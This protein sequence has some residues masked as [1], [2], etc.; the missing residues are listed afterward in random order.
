MEA[1]LQSTGPVAFQIHLPSE[2]HPYFASLLLFAAL[3]KVFLFAF[4]PFPFKD[5]NSRAPKFV[6][7]DLRLL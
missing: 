5:L 4:P 2:E 6:P 3:F 7:F 1:F